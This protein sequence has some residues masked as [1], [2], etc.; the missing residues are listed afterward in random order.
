[1][2]TFVNHKICRITFCLSTH[3]VVTNHAFISETGVPFISSRRFCGR[4]QFCGSANSQVK[5]CGLTPISKMWLIFQT[6]PKRRAGTPCQNQ[7]ILQRCCKPQHNATWR[8]E[9]PWFRDS[10]GTQKNPVPG[11]LEGALA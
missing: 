5:L 9:E 1:M 6:L 10:S 7:E 8:L 11:L 3:S 2:S 4:T